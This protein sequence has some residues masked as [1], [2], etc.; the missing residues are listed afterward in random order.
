MDGE[1]IIL[2]GE[3][4]KKR[5]E[6]DKLMRARGKALSLITDAK[7]R[8]IKEKTRA[9]SKKAAEEKDA[10]IKSPRFNKLAEYER[11]EDIQE[12]YGVDVINEAERDALEELWDEREEI[13][14][15]TVDGIYEDDVT[16]ALGL[17]WLAI[18]DL[19]E[20]LVTEAEITER[21]FKRQ[22]L[23]AE[24]AVSEWN[25]KVNEDYNRLTKG[26]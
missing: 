18:V 24:M 20:D 7:S 15:K 25:K 4:E 1:K 10:L 3:V 14:N 9:R 21:E 16:K 5:K 8:Y 22:R 26:E 17:A 12:A 6:A 2:P 13:K 11:R 23:E 19:W